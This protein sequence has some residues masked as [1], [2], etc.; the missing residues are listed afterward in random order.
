MTKHYS[1]R[2]VTNI[3]WNE[4]NIVFLRNFAQT[5]SACLLTSDILFIKFQPAATAN[6]ILPYHPEEIKLSQA[7][8]QVDLP[9]SF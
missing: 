2:K 1:Y 9:D 6:K 7:L 8:A 4:F 5:C 3:H